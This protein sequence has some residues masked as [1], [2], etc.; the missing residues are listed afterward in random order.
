MAEMGWCPSGR[1]FEAAACGVP[2]LSDCWPGLDGFFAPGKEILVARGPED[3]IAALDLGDA[4]LRRI[5]GAARDRVLTEHTSAHRAAEF[6]R[7]LTDLAA[8]AARRA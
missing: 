8:P 7:H 5:A 2:I 6:E 4:E 3:A 1:L